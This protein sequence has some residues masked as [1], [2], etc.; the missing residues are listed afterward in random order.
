MHRVRSPGPTQSLSHVRGGAKLPHI[1][2]GL[3]RQKDDRSFPSCWASAGD[4]LMATQFDRLAAFE[5]D[6]IRAL[7][8]E[9]GEQAKAR[10]VEPGRTPKLTPRRRKAGQSSAATATIGRCGKSPAAT[11][12][13]AV[14]FRD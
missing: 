5:R 8:D 7:S 11:M 1:A 10:R 14:R 3:I 4:I 9:G 6:L 13:A 12:L 2:S